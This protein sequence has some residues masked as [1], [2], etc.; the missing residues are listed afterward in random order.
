MATIGHVTKQRDG[1]YVGQLKTISISARLEIV[2][3]R[4]KAVANG[5]DYMV[6]SN[7]AEVGAGWNRIGQRSGKEYT[8]LSL[9]APEFGKEPLY[10]N[11]G[12]AAHQDDPDVFALIWN[13][14]NRQGGGVAPPPESE[15]EPDF[16]EP[17]GKKKK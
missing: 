14:A 1:R 8:S 15:P 3:V 4:N 7:G 6:Y 13:A 17:G 11:L 10:C 16:A 5:P 12:R 2:P 9:A